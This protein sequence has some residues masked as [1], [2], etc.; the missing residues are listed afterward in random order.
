MYFCARGWENEE[1]CL[2]RDKLTHGELCKSCNTS[3]RNIP[4][5]IVVCYYIFSVT[6]NIIQLLVWTSVVTHF[7]LRTIVLFYKKDVYYET[8]RLCKG[9]HVLDLNIS[10][11]HVE[12]KQLKVCDLNKVYLC[13]HLLGYAYKNRVCKFQKQKYLASFHLSYASLIYSAR[14]PSH[15]KGEWTR[16][17]FDLIDLSVCHS[18]SMPCMEAMLTL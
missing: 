17:I 6:R 5:V 3:H 9:L 16:A 15:W 7:Y 1:T 4:F 13:H 8:T 10:V 18:M 12:S 14:W 2:R 11:Y